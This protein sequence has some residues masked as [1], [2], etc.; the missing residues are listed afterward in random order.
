VEFTN[1]TPFPATLCRSAFGDQRLV[2]SLVCRVTFDIHED[3][4]SPSAQQPWKAQPGPWASEYGH[5]DGDEF[6]RRG[7]VDIFVF[8]TAVTP[9]GEPARTHEV[10]VTVG[11]DFRQRLVLFGDR[12]WEKGATGLVPSEPAPFVRMPLALDRSFGGKARWDGL[13]VPFPLNPDGKGYYLEDAEAVG[14]PLPNIEDPAHP[15]AA[16]DDRP[17]PVC[18]TVCPIHNPMRAL[19]GIELDEQ[20]AIKRIKLTYFN[21][22]F[23]GMIAARVNPGDLVTVAG[24][25][26]HGALRFHVPSLLLKAR[27]RFGSKESEHLLSIDQVG[28]EADRSRMFVSYRYPF[29]YWFNPGQQR[30]CTLSLGDSH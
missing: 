24:V 2:A 23:P 17:E 29:R 5:F 18:T 9:G 8:G 13:D 27:L 19:H 28:V 3:S 6:L 26:E 4:V 20:L 15:I 10:H 16:W 1:Q 22:A 11:Q 30:T 12:V 14:Q 7:G 25:R 21:S